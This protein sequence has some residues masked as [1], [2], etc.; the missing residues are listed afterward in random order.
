MTTIAYRDGLVAAD[1]QS[2]AAP[3]K[4][5]NPQHKVVRLADG[6][7]LAACGNLEVLDMTRAF[8]AG[9]ADTLHIEGQAIHFVSTDEI[10]VYQGLG[11][12]RVDGSFRSWGSGGAIADAAMLLGKSAEEAVA[13]AAM[14]DIFT[15]G[16]IDVLE[17]SK[18]L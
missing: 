12:Y 10:W 2:T 4:D 18:P 1:T 6:S 17:I 7:V 13:V 5:P 11:R 9:E 8:L 3:Y 14:I 15:G 16:P